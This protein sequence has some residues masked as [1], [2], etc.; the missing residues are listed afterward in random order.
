VHRGLELRSASWVKMKAQ[1]EPCSRSYVAS[2][3]HRLSCPD[4]SLIFLKKKIKSE[5]VTNCDKK[6][7]IKMINYGNL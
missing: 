7:K 5:V 1:K 4:S 3:A 2:A 6:I